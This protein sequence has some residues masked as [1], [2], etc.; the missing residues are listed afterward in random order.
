MS[1]INCKVYKYTTDDNTQEYMIFPVL[2]LS[3]YFKAHGWPDAL[4]C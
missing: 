1:Q 4:G 3:Y 2:L